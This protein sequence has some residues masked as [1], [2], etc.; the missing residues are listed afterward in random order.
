MLLVS[1]RDCVC[2]LSSLSA[3]PAVPS[4]ALLLLFLRYCCG[5]RVLVALCVILI[6]TLAV[7]FSCFI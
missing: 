5:F 1:S 7:A 4:Y 3:P 6:F 2:C